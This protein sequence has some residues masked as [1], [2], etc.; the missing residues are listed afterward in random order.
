MCPQS[1]VQTHALIEE[2]GL[3]IVG[4][5]HSHPDFGVDPSNIDIVNH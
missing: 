3:E 1:Q 2:A 5:Y 4:W